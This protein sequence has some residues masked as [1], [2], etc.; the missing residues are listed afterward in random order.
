MPTLRSYLAEVLASPDDSLAG[1]RSWVG[2]HL[3]T[4][5][6]ATGKLPGVGDHVG[7]GALGSPAESRGRAI[8]GGD[9]AGGIAGP[10]RADL[11]RN[12]QAGDLLDGGEDLANAEPVAVAQVADQ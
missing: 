11:D 12:R 8:R 7:Q 5:H 9:Q 2:L 4:R 3:V 1:A 6:G 10:P